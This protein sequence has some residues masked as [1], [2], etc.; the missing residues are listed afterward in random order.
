MNKVFFFTALSILCSQRVLELFLA[1][2]N[3][4][5]MRQNQAI[6]FG[7]QHYPWIVILHV[8]F[9]LS[10]GLEGWI[11]GPQLIHGW[12]III[13]LIGYL[14]VL[15]YWCIIS[16][17]RFWNTKI[18]T[19]PGV[20]KKRIGPYRLMRHPNYLIVVLEIFFWPLL[21]SCWLTLIW[22]GLANALVLS[23]RIREE[24]KALARL[25]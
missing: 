15:R 5:W 17:G 21:F 11:R 10:L 23:V 2:S 18:L 19:I 16:L 8:S 13:I 6:E 22:A 3:E 4:R 14:Q 12:L 7:R 1:R 24:N 20:E 9:I 25:I